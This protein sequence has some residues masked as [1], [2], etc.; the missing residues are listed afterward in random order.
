MSD[1]DEPSE[2][3]SFLHEPIDYAL[4]L[5]GTENRRKY[6][7]AFNSWFEVPDVIIESIAKAF[8]LICCSV[9]LIDD[10]Q[11][12]STLRCGF[13]VANKIYSSPLTINASNVALFKALAIINE[14]KC[15]GSTE[16]FTEQMLKHYQGQGI[17]IWWRESCVCPTEDEYRIMICNKIGSLLTIPI[18]L[19]KYFSRHIVESLDQLIRE[20]AIFLQYRADYLNLSCGFHES[21]KDF[22]E[23]ITEGKFTLPVIHAINTKERDTRIVN[24]LKQHTNDV[25]LKSYCVQLMEDFHSLEYTKNECE[26]TRDEIKFIIEDIGV[27]E[28]LNELID[29]LYFPVH[30][31]SI[32]D[33]MDAV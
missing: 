26:A 9:M 24:I 1:R 31:A 17:E 16:M 18:E 27:N 10:I 28:Q 2:E 22:A 29:R 25:E 33:C 30:E 3:Y 32:S 8:D 6:I 15:P 20:L 13:P 21:G 11:D 23:S 19:M 7:D 5:P 12:S 4:T 14:L